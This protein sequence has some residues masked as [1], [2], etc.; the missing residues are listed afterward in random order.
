LRSPPICSGRDVV[1]A[2]TMAPLGAYVIAFRA[3]ALRR[4]AGVCSPSYAHRA[5]HE[6][7]KSIVAFSRR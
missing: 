5:I 2:A 3:S 1:G 6:C 4:T 7:Q